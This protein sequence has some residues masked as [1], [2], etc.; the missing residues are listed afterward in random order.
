[1][2]RIPYPTDLTDEQ[3]KLVD[4]F[5]PKAKAGGRPRKTDLREVLNAL[6]YLVRTSCQ[7]RYLPKDFP[8]KSTMWRYFDEWRQ[9]GTLD[10]IHDRLRTKVRTAEKPSR[11]S[12]KWATTAASSRT[13][14]RLTS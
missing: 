12:S 9:D 14:P 6:L 10:L 1:M 11:S 2:E 5:L 4:P 3:W 8:P 13:K 7:W